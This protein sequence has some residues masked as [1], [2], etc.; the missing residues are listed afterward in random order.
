MITEPE[1]EVADIPLALKLMLTTSQPIAMRKS[2]EEIIETNWRRSLLGEAAVYC[3]SSQFEDQIN[4]F[5]QKYLHNFEEYID[6]KT[7]EDEEQNLACTVI[8]QEYQTLVEDLLEDFITSNGSTLRDFTAE[9]RS[10]LNGDF[11]ILFEEHEHKWFVD[12]LLSWIDYQTFFVEMV[13]LA[14]RAQLTRHK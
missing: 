6:C 12:A 4:K 1:A 9:C 3:S 7:S 11:T 8:F 14:R 10:S 5:K 2:G 13:K